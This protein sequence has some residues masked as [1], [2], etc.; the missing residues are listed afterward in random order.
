ME[1]HKTS[2]DDDL[3]RGAKKVQEDMKAKME[4]MLDSDKLQQ[5]TIAGTV[6][7]FD[8]TLAG[9]KRS[10]SGMLSVKSSGAKKADRKGRAKGGKAG[11][12]EVE[13]RLIQTTNV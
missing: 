3:K 4:I 13:S 6:V 1:P 5:F 9:R 7:E 8:E 12:G 2:V 11:K 10:Q